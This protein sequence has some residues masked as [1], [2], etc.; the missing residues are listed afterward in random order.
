[1]FAAL[2]REL[3]DLLWIAFLTSGLSALGVGLAIILVLALDGWH[4]LPSVTGHV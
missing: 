1:M 4:H 3:R 2:Q